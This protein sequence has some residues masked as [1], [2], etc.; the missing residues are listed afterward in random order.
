MSDP[1][2]LHENV[3][4]TCMGGFSNTGLTSALAS[5]EAVQELGVEKVSLGCLAAVP[6]NHEPVMKK[7][8][9]ARNII[10][11][12]GCAHECAR[13]VVEQAGL[14]VT[15]SI[16]LAR[17]IEM[18]KKSLSEDIGGDLKNVMDY[19]SQEEVQRAKELIVNTIKGL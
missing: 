18:K 1:I 4:F 10:T 15:R 8:R 14:E 16:V 5:L 3:I 9:A 19:I 2:R 6:I 12:D 17:D 11:V 13:K 7:T